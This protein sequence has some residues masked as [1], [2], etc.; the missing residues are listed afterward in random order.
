MSVGLP[1]PGSGP[2]SQLQV[3]SRTGR[4]SRRPSR[5]LT[6]G[7]PAVILLRVPS[8]FAG[9]LTLSEIGADLFFLPDAAVACR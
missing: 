1:G 6:L 9:P 4:F 2:K 3:R 5:E 8:L 7:P